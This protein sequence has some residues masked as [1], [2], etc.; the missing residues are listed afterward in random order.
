MSVIGLT[1]HLYMSILLVILDFYFPPYK[2]ATKE[3]YSPPSPFYL[4]SIGDITRR[5]TSYRVCNK[6]KVQKERSH[7]IS[8]GLSMM[9]LREKIDPLPDPQRVNQP[10]PHPA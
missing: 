5:I 8:F 2:N 7:T 10:S 1:F 4:L 9:A 6:G 3:K